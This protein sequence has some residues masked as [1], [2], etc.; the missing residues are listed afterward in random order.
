[1]LSHWNLLYIFHNQHT[2]IWTSHIE[3]TQESHMVYG[4]L[5]GGTVLDSEL[6]EHFTHH[7]V[8]SASKMPDMQ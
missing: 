2:S 6:R 1:M 8:L 7:Y 5:L 4:Q 3:S